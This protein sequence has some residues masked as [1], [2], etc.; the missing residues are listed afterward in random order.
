MSTRCFSRPRSL[1]MQRTE[2]LRT[3]CDAHLGYV[4][5]HGPPPTHL[6]YCMNSVALLY[7][8]RAKQPASKSY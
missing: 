8:P 7:T 2:V 4:F 1:G 6:R 3:R 5:D